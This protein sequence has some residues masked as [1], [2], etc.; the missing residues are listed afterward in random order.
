MGFTICTN[1]IHLPINV[2]EGLKLVSQMALM[3]WN[4]TSVW[5]IPTG[6]TG[7]FSDVPLLPVFF[8][9]CQALR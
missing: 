6:K 5:N 3:K 8:S 4:T 9:L 2:R 7:H 1:Q